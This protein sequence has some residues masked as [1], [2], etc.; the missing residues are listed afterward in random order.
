MLK[1]YYFCLVYEETEVERDRFS[2]LFYWKNTS[3]MEA[4]GNVGI[5]DKLC[6][7]M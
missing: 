4:F 7:P 3:G 5:L 1:D 6:L 2:L